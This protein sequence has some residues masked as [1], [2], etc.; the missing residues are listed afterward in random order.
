MVEAMVSDTGS[1]LDLI[2]QERDAVEGLIAAGKPDEEL[3][4]A[5]QRLAKVI[6]D[7][8][9]A[10]IHVKKHCAKPKKAKEQEGV[11]NAQPPVEIKQ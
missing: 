10:A 6:K 7:Y 3:L 8:K 9:E 4:L 1:H 2:Q 11:E 5:N